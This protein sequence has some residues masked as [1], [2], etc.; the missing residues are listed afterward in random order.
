MVCRE[1]GAE[2][3][4]P[5]FQVLKCLK[6]GVVRILHLIFGKADSPNMTDASVSG[7]LP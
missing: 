5:T 1:E 4:I 7:M 3:A 6:V 2:I